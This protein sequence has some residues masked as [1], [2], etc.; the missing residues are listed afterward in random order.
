[1]S[2]D[3]TSCQTIKQAYE[4]SEQLLRLLEDKLGK[5]DNLSY[6]PVGYLGQDERGRYETELFDNLNRSFAIAW[7]YLTSHT[8]KMGEDKDE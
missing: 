6:I 3:N 4:K 8:T 1:M 5:P 2:K 7:K